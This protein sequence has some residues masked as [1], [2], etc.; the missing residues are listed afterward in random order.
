MCHRLRDL[1]LLSQEG[2][3]DA[4]GLSHLIMLHRLSRANMAVWC[5]ETDSLV[6]SRQYDR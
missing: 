4:R 6:V 5:C 2:A 3:L 1:T